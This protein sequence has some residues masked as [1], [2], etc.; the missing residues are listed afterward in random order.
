MN[1]RL[2]R[3]DDVQLS[4]ESCSC[5]R[6]GR[7]QQSGRVNNGFDRLRIH[8]H[9][10]RPRHDDLEVCLEFFDSR[11]NQGEVLIAR[12]LLLAHDELVHNERFR[13]P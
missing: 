8:H 4:T 1:R 12:D 13:R 6:I 5:N 10:L 3:E 9:P 7:A 2:L 11:T